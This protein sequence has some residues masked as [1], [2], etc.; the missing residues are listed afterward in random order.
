MRLPRTNSLRVTQLAINETSD[1]T[2]PSNYRTCTLNHPRKGGKY[3]NRHISSV[4][5]RHRAQGTV[6]CL[7]RPLVLFR[8]ATILR[9]LKRSPGLKVTKLVTH[10]AEPRP[11]VSFVWF[12]YVYVC[13]FLFNCT[14]I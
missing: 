4:L 10:R 12:T 9:K 6:F 5:W 1:G 2:R 8:G 13:V 3:D 7:K 11:E 14:D